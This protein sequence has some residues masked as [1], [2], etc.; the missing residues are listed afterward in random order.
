MA[1]GAVGL[2]RDRAGLEKVGGRILVREIDDRFL[3]EPHL[4]A[5]A[6]GA[7]AQAVPFARFADGVF[8]VALV[9]PLVKVQA[10]GLAGGAPADVD[11]VRR[12]GAALGGFAQEH[13]AVVLAVLVDLEI[14]H[15]LEI[16]EMHFG[17]DH[18]PA[19]GIPVLTAGEHPFLHR[20]L[21]R[22]EGFPA[23]Q[24]VLRK[25]RVKLAGMQRGREGEQQE[26][27]AY[28]FNQWV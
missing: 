19:L 15:Q 25:E 17:L 1:F 7:N 2:Q 16:L 24:A 21:G 13:A 3:V 14:E 4:N 26:K 12:S 20:P 23:A 11:L 28:H 22:A 18:T 10:D 27:G 9:E 8:L 5:R 6:D